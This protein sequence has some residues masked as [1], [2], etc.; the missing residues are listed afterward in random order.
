MCSACRGVAGELRGGTHCAG[1]GR[2]P[3]TQLWVGRA[4]ALP[5]I[6]RGTVQKHGASRYRAHQLRWY[7][8]GALTALLAGELQLMFP[9]AGAVTPHIRAGRV[10]A[11][12]VTSAEPT[13][14]FPGVPS[15]SVTLPGY[16]VTS[17]YGVRRHSAVWRL[18]GKSWFPGSARRSRKILQRGHGSGGRTPEELAATVKSEVIRMGKGS[19][20]PASTASDGPAAAGAKYFLSKCVLMC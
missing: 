18:N 17:V 16:E 19:A 5:I 8:P 11:L 15:M 20:K 2:N 4:P 10:K 9:T 7:S 1:Q 12:A 13:A 3:R 14:L 6:S